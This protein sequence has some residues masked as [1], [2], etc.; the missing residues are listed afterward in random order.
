MAGSI[1]PNG[2]PS[3]FNLA[4]N[5]GSTNNVQA[6]GFLNSVFN[7]GGDENAVSAIGILNNGTKDTRVN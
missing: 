4:V 2:P 7:I 6:N 1:A 3:Y 5:L